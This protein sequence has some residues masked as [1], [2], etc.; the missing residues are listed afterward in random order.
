[1]IDEINNINDDILKELTINKLC[2]ET[3]ISKEVI[4]DKLKPK[5]EKVIIKK[6]N[7]KNNNKYEKSVENL[8]FHMLYSPEVI[9]LY[10]KKVTHIFDD[11]YRHLGF[12]ICAFYKQHGYINVSDLLT[13]LNDDEETT[14]TIG[15][16][17]A[18]GLKEEYTIDEIEDYLKNIQ[19]YNDLKKVDL[20]KNELSMSE[21][22]DEKLE[23]AKKLIEYKLRSEENDR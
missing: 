16:V 13:E 18:L 21:D 6:P 14:K 10:D 22:L 20:Y 3:K 1:M 11:N 19:E 9:Q 7:K 5:E 2:N 23:L 8:I 12:Q 4:L 15:K 17:L